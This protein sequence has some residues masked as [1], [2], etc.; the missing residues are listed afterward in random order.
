MNN[1]N[2][3]DEIQDFITEIEASNNGTYRES[4]IGTFLNEGRRTGLLE[5]LLLVGTNMLIYDI[6]NN[7]IENN[8]VN[9]VINESFREKSKFKNVLSEEGEKQIKRVKYDADL[10]KN[11]ICPIYHTEFTKDTIVSQL[12]C[13]HIFSP[14]GID[15]WLKNENAICPVCRFKLLSYEKKIEEEQLIN[16]EINENNENNEYTDG[17][18]LNDISYNLEFPILTNINT[19]NNINLLNR[20]SYIITR[21]MEL[22]EEENFQETI[23]NSITDN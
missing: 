1:I 13:N 10:H 16:R 15:R 14:E 21:G 9:R 4:L 5:S 17:Y 2:N 18:I 22:E 3:N 20:F 6:S 8:I 19:I 23:F 12:P 7:D 11:H